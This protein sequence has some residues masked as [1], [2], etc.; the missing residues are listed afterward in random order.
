ME[1]GGATSSAFFKLPKSLANQSHLIA[2]RSTVLSH[3]LTDLRPEA[4]LRTPNVSR[5]TPH[6]LHLPFA[7]RH[8]WFA[9]RNSQFFPCY[10]LLLTSDFRLLISD[11]S[12]PTSAL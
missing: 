6:A 4:N 11:F 7:L 10:L 1:Q 12:R 5:L 3:P 9:I 2:Y 8:L